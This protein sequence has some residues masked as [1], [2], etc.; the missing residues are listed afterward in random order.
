MGRAKYWTGTAWTDIAPSAAEFDA[1]T[2]TIPY[3]VSTGTANVYVIAAPT[4]ASLVAG[5]AVSVKFNVASTGASTLNWNSKGAKSIKKADGSN[6]TNIKAGGVYTLRYDGTNFIIQGEG[7]EYGTAIASEVLSGKTIGTDTGLVTG[8]MPNLLGVRTAT[9]TALWGDGGIA[10]YPERGY[11]KGG[12]GDGEIKVTSAQL[13]STDGGLAPPNI[14]SGV[15][16]FGVVGSYAGD[17]AYTR[18]IISNQSRPLYTTSNPTLTSLDPYSGEVWMTT[19]SGYGTIG[20]QKVSF[21]GLTPWYGNAGSTDITV[22]MV[23]PAGNTA[24]SIGGK[25]IVRIAK[26]TVS[27][28]SS[29][30]VD[31]TYEYGGNLV[32]TDDSLSY[33]YKVQYTPAVAGFTVVRWDIASNTVGMRGPLL[34]NTDNYPINNTMA[35]DGGF[36]YYL[37]PTK[38]L[39]KVQ[40]SNGVLITRIALG[41]ITGTPT[42]GYFDKVNKLYYIGDSVGRIYRYTLSGALQWYMQPTVSTLGVDNIRTGTDGKIYAFVRDYISVVNMDG[43]VFMANINPNAGIAAKWCGEICNG[44]DGVDQVIFGVNYPGHTTNTTYLNDIVIKAKPL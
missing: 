39:V 14:K 34:H 1:F 22:G 30:N 43:S 35:Y 44:P 23:F 4:I 25:Q 8:T 13:Q 40:A 21:R 9:G 12:T 26:D 37:L 17:L 32:C 31:P 19:T 38:E 24:I 33:A 18:P 10:V 27:I 11:Q 2:T 36:V 20:Y 41:G 15:R 6:M 16:I 29:T 42:V 3:A 7:G 5:M 28:Q